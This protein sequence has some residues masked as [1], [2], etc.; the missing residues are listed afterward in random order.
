MTEP[1]P[2]TDALTIQAR[3]LLKA[4][5]NAAAAGD[6]KIALARL[7]EAFTLSPQ[8]LDVQFS[9]FD[10]L[11]ATGG[12]DLPPSFTD[13][14]THAAEKGMHEIQQ[15]APIVRNQFKGSLNI[16][17]TVKALENQTLGQVLDNES[18]DQIDEIFGSKLIQQVLAGAISI[19]PEL[20]TLLTALRRFHLIAWAEGVLDTLTPGSKNADILPL[21]ARQA[22]N[23]QYIFSCCDVEQELV[24]SLIDKVKCNPSACSP[25]ILALAACYFPLNATLETHTPE[26]IEQLTIKA[27]TWPKAFRN[28]WRVQ[29][30]EPSYE[31]QIQ[32]EL[33]VLTDL[34]TVTEDQVCEQYE[35]FPYPCWQT[36]RVMPAISLDA[37]LTAQFGKAALPELSSEPVNIL[38]A[39]CGTGKQVVSIGK[40]IN[41]KNILAFDIS[42]NS[43]SHAYR[44][45]Q[46]YEMPNTHFALAD[47][48][49]VGAW[50]ASF[51]VIICTGVLHHL[52]NASAGLSALQCVSKPNTVFFLALY[53]KQGR[54]T[55]IAAQ[56]YIS[57]NNLND[58]PENIRAMR[59]HIQ[60][61]P[62]S[63][64]MFEVQEC[65]EFF[66]I[67]GLHDYIFNKLENCYT[68][69]DLKALLIKHK[70][71]LIGFQNVRGD[72]KTK[73]IDQFPQDTQMTNLDNWE[74]FEQ[75]YP[76]T[77][78]GMMQF[79]CCPEGA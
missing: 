53:S 10:V 70:L 1:E 78:S 55:A 58:S 18:S 8:D 2:P 39:G 72:L 32:S 28:L 43:L 44:K 7:L 37:Y 48:T 26:L 11:S 79:W 45:A 41:S 20:E 13:A 61:L 25:N 59:T 40:A 23:T 4:G 36:T 57:A 5:R 71:R 54:K 66:S 3:A 73:Y 64:P 60:A 52:E 62:P 67:N 69:S 17:A 24:G 63:D 50:D 68:P 9:L 22:F 56:E 47:V 27:S 75:S 42:K 38:F 30:M 51:D 16:D 35:N 74:K 12:Y 76:E 49:Q 34:P 29:I 46:E 6:V 65:Q 19:S 31:K 77:F 15:L 21:I 14:I 33:Q